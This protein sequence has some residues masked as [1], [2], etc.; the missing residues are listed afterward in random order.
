MKTKQPNAERERVN[1]ALPSNLL[2]DIKEIAAELYSTG[3][4]VNLTA[5]QLLRDAVA[6]YEAAKPEKECK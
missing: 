5:E 3:G 4:K 6:R 2:A 1:W